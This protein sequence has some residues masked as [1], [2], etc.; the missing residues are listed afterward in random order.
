MAL[1]NLIHCKFALL[2]KTSASN[3]LVF[4]AYFASLQYIS[5]HS[6]LWIIVLC[7]SAEPSLTVNTSKYVLNL[8]HL[9]TLHFLSSF[10]A[11]ASYS[12]SF[13][14][15]SLFDIGYFCQCMYYLQKFSRDMSPGNILHENVKRNQISLLF[16]IFKKIKKAQVLICT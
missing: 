15:F 6:C 13:L 2:S 8:I 5:C 3:V 11:K 4:S 16:F 1:P 10:S 9:F 7:L 14:C 12:I